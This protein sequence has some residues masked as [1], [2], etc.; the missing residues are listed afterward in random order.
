MPRQKKICPFTDRPCSNCHALFAEEGREK[1]SEKTR[2]CHLT[3]KT[4]ADGN[5]NK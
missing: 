2:G 1:S 5:S 4:M 3:K